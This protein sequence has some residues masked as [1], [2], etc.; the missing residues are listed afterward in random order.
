MVF[1]LALL[2]PTSQAFAAGGPGEW[3]IEFRQQWVWTTFGSP[4]GTG[5]MEIVDL[6]GDGVAELVAT[7]DIDEW[8]HDGVPRW[9]E[10]RYDGSVRQS[11]S[12]LGYLDGLLYVRVVGA[13][14]A[15]EVLVADNDELFI[16][17]AASK[18]HTRTIPVST[19]GLTAV[20]VGDLDADG[21]LEIAVCDEQ[22]LY[23]YDYATGD[24]VAAR[25]GFG[26]T[27][28]ELGQTDADP[29]LEIALAGNAFGGLLLDGASL[30][31][32]WA[33]LD[34][35]GDRLCLS[36]LD[37]DGLDEVVTDSQGGSLLLALDPAS[38]FILWQVDTDSLGS[39]LPVDVDGT[40]DEELVYAERYGGDIHAIEETDGTALW[41]IPLDYAYVEALAAGDVDADG[42][43]EL[44]WSEEDYG[45]ALR[46]W[47]LATATPMARSEVLI[48]PFPGIHI[49]DLDGDGGA[50]V[51]ATSASSSDGSADQGGRHLAFDP[52][53]HVLERL[54][55]PL[56]GSYYSY[57]GTRR[58]LILQTD[59][60]PAL[61][62][63]TAFSL[64]Y[65]ESFVRC[66]DGASFA[67]EWQVTFPED[68]IPLSLAAAELDGDP[69]PE[70]VVGT[71]GSCL[72]VLEAE[73][74]W[75]KYQTQP[76]ATS[77]SFQVL[78][79]GDVLGD[80]APELVAASGDYYYDPI[81]I[82]NGATGA[83]LRG[84]WELSIGS[85]D[86]AQLDADPQLE[87]VT[88]GT[89]GSISILDAATG[90]LGPELGSFPDQIFALRVADTTVDGVLDFNVVS[91]Y[92]LG[93]WGGAEGEVVWTGP[94][95]GPA[96]GYNDTL[97]VDDY[98]LDTGPELAVNTGYGF[99]IFEAPLLRI[100]RD[101]F[102]SGDTSA[103]TATVP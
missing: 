92:A 76:L 49:A 63:C 54:S 82:F 4:I 5:G 69:D 81:A 48:G 60:D 45:S 89:D 73:S 9:F 7:A 61:E 72:V 2:L 66:E 86:L 85:F 1:A 12:S 103:W 18:V 98:D 95:L 50:D 55:P 35:F 52:V 13:P 29:A 102:E 41:T 96:A 62:I 70:L 67:L 39:F 47:D 94:Y 65:D 31:L 91:G 34:G 87:I 71:S 19:I 28:L 83:L 38:G 58:T 14:G 59:A 16:Y 77:A 79:V 78:R 20:E 24:E 33:H 90:Q 6:D 51:V 74:G 100:F 40:G 97:W 27:D 99:A 32:D 21:D 25:Y 46:V 10:A 88:G 43:L 57:Q 23:I 44:V 36:D 8:Y 75:L 17:S 64:S 3:P 22:A 93:V 42:Q 11:W 84:P 30:L 101:G 53:S 80:D 68:I 56:P 26:C 15:R 37:H